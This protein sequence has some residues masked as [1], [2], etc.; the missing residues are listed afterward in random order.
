LQRYFNLSHLTRQPTTGS[1]DSSFDICVY[2][3][4]DDPEEDER[5]TLAACSNDSS[6]TTAETFFG[7]VLKAFDESY[8]NSSVVSQVSV[9]TTISK[10]TKILHQQRKPVI[11]QQLQLVSLS[12]VVTDP[13]FFFT[14]HISYSARRLS[15]G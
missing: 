6:M 15:A 10:P 1:P 14:Y 12:V 7:D 11:D 9:R 3:T 13:T 2:Y 5:D 4:R 8:Y